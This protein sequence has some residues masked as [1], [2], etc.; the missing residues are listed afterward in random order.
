[1]QLSNYYNEKA[2]KIEL[3]FDEYNLKITAKNP[4]FV[5]ISK[6][7]KQTKTFQI[8]TSSYFIND[9]IVIPLLYS[10]EALQSASGLEM[11][12]EKPAKLVIKGATRT[13]DEVNNP[14]FSIT[15]S[16][17]MKNKWYSL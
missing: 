8:S 10:I 5:L 1:M 12:F 3:K 9:E 11:K 6:K 14:N 16:P 2:G 7:E 15:R 13:K 4:Y 17:W